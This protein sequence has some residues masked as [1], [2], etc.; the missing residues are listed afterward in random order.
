MHVVD[1]FG[2]GRFDPALRP[3]PA[4]QRTQTGAVLN[5]SVDPESELNTEKE[6]VVDCHFEYVS[7]AAFNANDVN[8]VQGVTVGGASGGTFSLGVEGQSTTAKG[9]GD[10]AG[11]ASGKGD[12]IAGSNTIAGV[13]ASAGAFA[14]GQQLS[15]VGIPQDAVVL[16]V[17]PGGIVLSV[18]ATASGEGVALS[19]VSDEVTAVNATSGAF[20]VGEEIGGAGVPPGTTIVKATPGRLTLSADT[21]SGAGDALSAALSYDSSAAEVQSALESLAPVGAGNIAVKG[22]PGGPYTVQFMGSLADTAVPQLTTDASGLTPG[23]AMVTSAIQTQGGEGWGT[24]K[25]VTCE[26]PDAG[27]IPKSDAETTVHAQIREQLEAGASYRFRLVA[28]VGGKLG[29]TSRSAVA[30][31]AVPHA[32]RVTGT[33]ASGITSTFARLSAEVDPLGVDTTYQFQYFLW[34]GSGRMGNRGPVR[35][36]RRRRP[37]MS[38]RVVKRGSSPKR[39]SRALGA[40]RRG[41]RTVSGWSRRMKRV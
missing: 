7:E 10:L 6:G 20:A 11:P 33:A 15:G 23:G 5:G 22:E 8:E 17:Q 28:T 31:F 38:A 1:E 19:A 26:H 18:D 9:T 24:A 25:S 29:G 4:S 40:W 14:V 32:P 37:W 16:S 35:L 41:P 27:E 21:A 39:S 12:L 30:S 3:V 13:S 36:S 2:L 34:N